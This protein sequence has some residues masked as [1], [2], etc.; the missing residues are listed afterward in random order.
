MAGVYISMPY[1]AAPSTQLMR[2]CWRE[3]LTATNGFRGAA[4]GR[5]RERAFSR[6]TRWLQVY[7]MTEFLRP[8]RTVRVKSTSVDSWGE[9]PT[10][11]PSRAHELVVF[12][13]LGSTL[14]TW[15]R[16]MA[17]SRGY[18]PRHVL[19]FTTMKRYFMSVA[20][21]PRLSPR[22]RDMVAQRESGS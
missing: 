21:V 3:I 18:D 17:N 16:L 8:S 9:K 11:S 14:R 20:A 13:L 12:Q 1:G 19:F 6:S 4:R 15:E 10:T 7:L 22:A 2:V 5:M